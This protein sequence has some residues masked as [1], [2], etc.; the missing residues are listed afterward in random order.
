M[1]K[2]SGYMI[3]DTCEAVGISRSSY[4]YALREKV[5]YEIDEGQWTHGESDNSQGEEN[6][7]K[8]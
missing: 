3:T 8:K 6:F 2:G 5:A 4:Y 1:L 7:S